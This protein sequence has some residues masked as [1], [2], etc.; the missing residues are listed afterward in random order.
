M[1]DKITMNT[2]LNECEVVVEETVD[3]DTL[4]KETN[5]D[6]ARKAHEESEAKRKAEWQ[7]R[8][9]RITTGYLARYAKL[10]TS[11]AKGAVLK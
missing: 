2:E 4:E 10:V 5:A 3:P 8:E 11:G 7:P 1:E 9:P 6:A